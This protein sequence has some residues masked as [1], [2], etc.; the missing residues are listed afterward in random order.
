[1]QPRPQPAPGQRPPRPP[2]EPRPP[3]TRL[4]PPAPRPP[5]GPSSGRPDPSSVRARSYG[6]PRGVDA[7]QL[8]GEER[9]DA[10]PVDGPG[11]VH[12]DVD[13]DVPHVPHAERALQPVL[14]RLRGQEAPGVLVALDL[15]AL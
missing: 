10:P 15:R 12:D 3:P 5:P 6:Q 9:R 4:P 1:P 8:C 7:V 14:L 13:Q 2:P 11:R